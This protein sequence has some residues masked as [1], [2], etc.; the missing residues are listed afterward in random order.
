[1]GRCEGPAAVLAV[2]TAVLLV[3]GGGLG[4]VALLMAA[5][6]DVDACAL[7]SRTE[8]TWSTMAAYDAQA[9]R[10]SGTALMAVVL[11]ARG[12]GSRSSAWH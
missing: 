7:S 3:E 6:A 4:G 10:K 12:H 5:W 9:Q 1:M 8:R 11:V 2:P